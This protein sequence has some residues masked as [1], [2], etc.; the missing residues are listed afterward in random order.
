VSYGAEIASRIADDCSARL[1]ANV[2][3]VCSMDAF[4]GYA[5]RSRGTS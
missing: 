3:R 5:P 2:R 4:V 1:D